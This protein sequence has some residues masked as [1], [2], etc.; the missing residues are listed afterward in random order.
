LSTEPVPYLIGIAGPSCAGK[1]ELTRQLS[2]LLSATVLPLDSYYRDLSHLPLEERACQNFDTPEAI[3]HQLFAE[4]LEALAAGREIRRPVYDFATHSRTGQTETVR[5]E[6]YIIVEGLFVLYWED[7]RRMLT[8]KVF[9][10]LDDRACLDRRILR[11]V[12]ERGRTPESV[13]LQFSETVRPMAE[14]YI[15]PTRAFADVAVCGDDPLEASVAAVVAHVERNL[16]RISVPN[17]AT[18]K[19]MQAADKGEGTKFASPDALLKDL[20]I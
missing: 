9:V 5:P 17:A 10:D 18:E 6:R 12:K 3:D 11:D 2:R 8:T 13:I 16:L 4:H 7:V 15:R 14:K 19:A 1:S 20:G